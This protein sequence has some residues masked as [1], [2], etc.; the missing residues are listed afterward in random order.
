M[1]IKN[2]ALLLLVATLFFSCA[3]TSSSL[4]NNSNIVVQQIPC[5]WATIFICCATIT[6][7]YKKQRNLPLKWWKTDKLLGDYLPRRHK[8]S[9]E[10][11]SVPRA[12]AWVFLPK[13]SSSSSYSNSNYS[14]KILKMFEQP[15]IFKVFY[16]KYWGGVK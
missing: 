12:W 11:R 2:S 5:P 8:K 15:N 13:T 14:V 3:T 7:A 6:I 4:Y 9:S 16:K 1:S 10:K